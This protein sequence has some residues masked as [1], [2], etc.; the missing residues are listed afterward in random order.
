MQCQ[1]YFIIKKICNQ[2][3][4]ILVATGKFLH[5]E[6]KISCY[7]LGN[8]CPSISSPVLCCC[9]LGSP[10]RARIWGAIKWVSLGAT[11]KTK[12]RFCSFAVIID[13]NHGTNADFKQFFFWWH[14][15]KFLQPHKIKRIIPSQ[16]PCFTKP[17]KITKFPR[18]LFLFSENFATF[19]HRF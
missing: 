11:R 5:L 14:F 7:H 2:A 15:T 12:M 13:T 3:Q 1:N 17:E 9:A 4:K 8:S 18:K 19:L 6:L 10:L 16:T